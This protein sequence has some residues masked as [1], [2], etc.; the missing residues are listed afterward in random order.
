MFSR[1]VLPTSPRRVR[2]SICATLPDVLPSQSYVDADIQ[3]GGCNVDAPPPTTPSIGFVSAQTRYATIL[4]AA[5]RAA[6]PAALDPSDTSDGALAAIARH[7]VRQLLSRDAT[8]AEITALT[9]EMKGCLAA[10]GNGCDDAEG[11][12]RWLCARLVD[13]AEFTLY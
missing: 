9:A 1:R 10:G 4:C 3:L 11:A 5:G 13:S 2:A 8:A 6:V 7:A 12:A